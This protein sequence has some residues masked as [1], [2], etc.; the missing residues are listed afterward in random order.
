LI[1]TAAIIKS[2]NVSANICRAV[3]LVERENT[4]TDDVILCEFYIRNYALHEIRLQK[5]KSSG[6][7]F[8]GVVLVF[9]N[10]LNISDINSGIFKY[11]EKY[12]VDTKKFS[13]AFYAT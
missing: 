4:Y 10:L 9:R 3:A 11:T 1:N 8:I 13:L 6:R 2:A 7:L 5:K 12:V